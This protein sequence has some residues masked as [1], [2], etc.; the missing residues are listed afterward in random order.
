[1]GINPDASPAHRA[2]IARLMAAWNSSRAAGASSS[3][4]SS[5]QVIPPVVGDLTTIPES[6]YIGLHKTYARLHG[7]PRDEDFP[8]QALLESLLGMLATGGLKAEPLKDVAS[9]VECETS[10]SPSLQVGPSGVLKVVKAKQETAPPTD[11]EGLRRRVRLMAVGWEVLKLKFPQRQILVD[12]AMDYWDQSVSWLLGPEIYG[13]VVLSEAG[14]I[15]HRSSW[16]NL[17]NF[18]VEVRK[19]AAH[20]INFEGLSLIQAMKKAQESTR[21]PPDRAKAELLG[22]INYLAAAYLLLE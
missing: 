6:E 13:L 21:L 8:G 5:P 15:S 10:S 7:L 1:L 2:A 16:P 19:R 17:L 18:E 22:A 20:F 4:S 11:T 9:K 14:Y 3:A 12:D